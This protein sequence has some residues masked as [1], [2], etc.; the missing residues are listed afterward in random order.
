MRSALHSTD[1]SNESTSRNN[2]A[3]LRACFMQLP[4]HTLSLL[5]A[6]VSSYFEP[7]SCSCLLML[8][9]CI[10]QLSHYIS[11]QLLKRPR[12]YEPASCSCLYSL[13]ASSLSD[14]NHYEPASSSCLFIPT[15]ELLSAN[16]GFFQGCLVQHLR[17]L[18]RLSCAAS[19]SSSSGLP[20]A[21]FQGFQGCNLRQTA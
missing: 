9:A 12:Y 5:H 20:C 21:V 2:L 13:R 17:V 4:L 15:R 11:S 1:Y 10:M 16:S 8:R 19:S 7:A 3:N 18:S 6:V 14:L